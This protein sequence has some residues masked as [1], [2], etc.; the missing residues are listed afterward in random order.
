MVWQRC[1]IAKQN[2]PSPCNYGWI[3][4]SQSEFVPKYGKYLCIPDDLLELTSCSCKKGRC[5]PP[6]KCTQ[7]QLT[8]SEVCLCGGVE[9]NCDNI[10]NQE[11]LLI[12]SDEEL[13]DEEL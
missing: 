7:N 5:R 3:I 13:S 2:L 10:Q 4:N 9:E 1:C 11:E 12:E 8:C 6:C